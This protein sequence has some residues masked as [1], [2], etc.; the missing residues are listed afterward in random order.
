MRRAPRVNRQRLGIPHIRQ[1][2]NELEPINHLR[3]GRLAALDAKAQHTAI[4]ALEVLLG[5]VM[6]GM[7]LQAGVRHPRDVGIRLKPRRELDGVLRVAL[8]AQRQR[9]EPEDELL[10]GEGV[11]AGANVALQLDARADDEAD[12]AERLPELE[13]VVARG[14]LDELREARG[15][16]APV[17]LAAVDDDAADCGAVPADPLGRRVHDDVGAVVK[18]A[19]EVAARAEGVVDLDESVL[20]CQGRG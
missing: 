8:A 20:A 10:R 11:E 6:R 16:G 19:D 9:L 13:P 7:A 2:R 18:G 17:E 1:I 12:G 5:R 14:W 4:P 3:P 15:V